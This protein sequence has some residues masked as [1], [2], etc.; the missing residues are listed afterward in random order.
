MPNEIGSS[1][2]RV[3]NFLLEALA[4]ATTLDYLDQASLALAGGDCQ[5]S[6]IL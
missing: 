2:V 5:F 1:L 6:E 3:P 4:P